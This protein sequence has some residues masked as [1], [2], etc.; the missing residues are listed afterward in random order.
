MPIMLHLSLSQWSALF[1]H[2][3]NKP[4]NFPRALI[5]SAG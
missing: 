2:A 4:N 5:V 3:D 1:S